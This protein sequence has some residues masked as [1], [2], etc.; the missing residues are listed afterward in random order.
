MAA[1]ARSESISGKRGWP[2]GGATTSGV[3]PV[4]DAGKA[5]AAPGPMTGAVAVTA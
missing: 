1:M 2:G 5:C 4:P 3:V